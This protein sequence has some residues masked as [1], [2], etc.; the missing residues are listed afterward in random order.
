MEVSKAQILPPYKIVI[1][2]PSNIF[3]KYDFRLRL[4]H[5]RMENIMGS[6]LQISLNLT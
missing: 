5:C 4:A 6:I 2:E 1:E 3:P